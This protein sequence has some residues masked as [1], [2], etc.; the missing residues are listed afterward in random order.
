MPG[1]IT[2]AI[3]NRTSLLMGDDVLARLK[4][5][6]VILFGVGGV[7]SW[8]AEGLIRGGIGHLT[9]V[10]SDRV[11]VTNVN[12]QLMATV[13]TIGEVK[14]EAMKRRLLDINPEAD[15]TALQKIYEDET[16][17]QFDLNSYDY[18]LDAVDSLKDKMDLI[19]NA[20]NSSAT[21]FSSMGAAL[22][23]DPT[24]VRVAAF[25]DVKG[26]PLGFLLRKNLRRQGR[27]PTRKFLCV[28]DDEVLENRGEEREVDPFIG[29]E[30]AGDP[31]LANHDWTEKKASINGTTA[32]VTAIF[33]MT[34]A[35][36]VIQDIYKKVTD[37][38]N[39][40]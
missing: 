5:T 4:D 11:S 38:E 29:A 18:V 10:D 35:G 15:V 36:L 23:V 39:D 25:A 13:S 37:N 14:V 19:V 21:F 16:A 40:A 22:K 1:G 32:H 9:L 7:G 33:G 26:C 12:R 31:A 27:F 6:R 30:D 3:Y 24:R 28:Y 34:L 20:C 2:D 8:C 17:G